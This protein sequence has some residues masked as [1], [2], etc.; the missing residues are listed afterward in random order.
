MRHENPAKF[1]LT[2]FN[3]YNEDGTLAHERASFNHATGWLYRA[4]GW[5][6][7]DR[8]DYV[9][10]FTVQKALRNSGQYGVA[11]LFA[12]STAA[13]GGTYTSAAVAHEA[14]RCLRIAGHFD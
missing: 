13:T 11:G 14:A 10:V 8:P 9:G 2:R 7:E 3:L 1:D 6:A 12:I 4:Q 5:H